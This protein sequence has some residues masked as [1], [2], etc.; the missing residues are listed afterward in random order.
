M[1]RFNILIVEDEFLIA[2]ELQTR[3]NGLGYS[4]PKIVATGHEALAAIEQQEPDLV[5]MDINL[6]GNLDGISVAKI[7]KERYQIPIIFLTSNTDDLTFAQ[8]RKVEPEAFLSKP[9]RAKDLQH[10]IELVIQKLDHQESANLTED[11][12][13]MED[14]IFVK[15]HNR[16]HRVYTNDICYIEADRAYCKLITE[17][18]DFHLSMSLKSLYERIS[19]P[20]L[21]RVH[22]SYVVN[23]RKMSSFSD[24]YVYFGEVKIPIGRAYRD[25]FFKRIRTV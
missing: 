15:H 18:D 13:V 20:N 1:P 11:T 17:T 21:I 10:A 5:L 25:D 2:A 16:M 7:I 9:F 4:V 3:L 22:R 23:I 6:W 12:I 14:R 24:V 19:L 8:A